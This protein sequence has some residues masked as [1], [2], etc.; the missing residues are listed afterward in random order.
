MSK[1]WG[2]RKRDAYIAKAQERFAACL[3]TVGPFEQGQNWNAYRVCITK[4]YYDSTPG[5]EIPAQNKAAKFARAY[6]RWYRREQAK[7]GVTLVLGPPQ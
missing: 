6:L 2:Q 1:S 7:R 5:D 4:F 3:F